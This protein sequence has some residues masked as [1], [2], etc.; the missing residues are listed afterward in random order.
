MDKRETKKY[1]AKEL[2]D[3]QELVKYFLLIF[4]F[5]VID[6]DEQRELSLAKTLAKQAMSRNENTHLFGTYEGDKMIGIGQLG[7]IEKKGNK[8][9]YLSALNVE[10]RYRGRGVSQSLTEARIK[11]ALENGCDYIVTDVFYDN[12]L[13]L[14]TKFKDG[15]GLTGYN[16][17]SG[18]F[19][20]S[21]RINGK[22][23]FDR[24]DNLG[25]LK[26]L[27]LTDLDS[28]EDLTKKGW[29]GIDIKNIGDVKDSHP[30]NW[31]LI[32]EKL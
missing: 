29:V 18:L 24:N 15:F 6:R 19:T 4:G 7:I 9:G 3:E 5:D 20:L 8:Y 32:L 16:F 13:G 11:C 14:V 12:P 21:K 25:K 30:A 27:P 28:I 2:K 17:S 26:E 31:V 1:S 10:P 23:N 22:E